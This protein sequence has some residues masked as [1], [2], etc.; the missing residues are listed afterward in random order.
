MI[1]PSLGQLHLWARTHDQQQELGDYLGRDLLSHISTTCHSLTSLSPE[2]YLR[3]SSAD[4][5]TFFRSMGQLKA[6]RL[7][8]EMN[9]VL[10]DA[11]MI[12][13]FSL[14]HLEDLSSDLQLDQAFVTALRNDKDAKEI[15][16]CIKTLEINFSERGGLAPALL[17]AVIH[18]VEQ[19]WITLAHVTEGQ[20]VSLHPSTFEMIGLMTKLV[21]LQF[22]LQPGMQITYN[23]LAALSDLPSLKSLH[24]SRI[25][26]HGDP[27]TDDIQVSGQELA[28]SLLGFSS[29]ESLWLSL[30]PARI[31]AT[32]DEA[33]IIRHRLAQVYPGYQSPINLDVDE[34]ASF[35]WPSF[36]NPE[37]VSAEPF[38]SNLIWRASSKN[39]SPDPIEWAP[40]NLNAYT[41]NNGELFP[42]MTVVTDG[43]YNHLSDCGT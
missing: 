20:N 41:D 38:P 28:A 23:E 27:R 12:E 30:M 25:Y 36:D 35:G 32:Y 8:M 37:P 15:L 26:R 9:S 39:F 17:L 40:R 24:I 14:P 31:N 22:Q 10:S 2:S 16:P 5:Y 43:T 11:I 18:T 29:L 33:Q 13:V 1:N 42:L 4:F 34:A 21:A 19:L 3:I 7:G 6:L